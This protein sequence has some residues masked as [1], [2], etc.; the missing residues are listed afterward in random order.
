MASMIFMV[1]RV[2]AT[3]WTLTM[4][5]PFKTAAATEAWVPISTSA[6]SGLISFTVLY[7]RMFRIKAFLEDPIRIGT[8][9][10]LN[11]CR[12]LINKRLCSTVFPKPIPG[13]M[14]IF[15]FEIPLLLA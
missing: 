3:L 1:A 8:S 13:S 14:M 5:A 4:W 12:C 15:D 6:R 9:S 11:S 2:L 10:V 7:L